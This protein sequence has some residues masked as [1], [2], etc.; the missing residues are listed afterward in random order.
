M[1]RALAELIC[2]GAGIFISLASNVGP[3]DPLSDDEEAATE[4]EVAADE[5]DGIRCT[6]PEDCPV[7]ACECAAGPPVNSRACRNKV[8]ALPTEI[9]DEYCQAFGTTW[10]GGY[11]YVSGPPEVADAG[12]GGSADAGTSPDCSGL[13]NSTACGICGEASCCLELAAC[14]ADDSCREIPPCIV[15]CVNQ[16]AAQSYCDSYC[17]SY[18]SLGASLFS[19]YET[20]MDDSCYSECH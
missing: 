8:C 15:A 19:Q 18:F 10:T 6:A 13:F 3:A 20:C 17:E 14:H 2:L 7:W 1:K 4:V 9:C 12:G 5:G 11:S 16:G